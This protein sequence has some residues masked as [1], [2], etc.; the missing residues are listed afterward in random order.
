[1]LVRKKVEFMVHPWLTCRS[2]DVKHWKTTAPRKSFRRIF[3]SI[4]L[5]WN[6]F[7]QSICLEFTSW[8]SPFPCSKEPWVT[9]NPIHLCSLSLICNKL[10][11][12]KHHSVAV[13]KRR[14]RYL[15]R[16]K[17]YMTMILQ[18]LHVF[19]VS[20]FREFILTCNPTR[21]QTVKK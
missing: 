11:A 4:K 21:L 8:F 14:V 12:N 15:N 20:N 18:L 2:A 1:M 3:V 10:G 19:H 6:E 13:Q 5:G 16:P 17:S 9:F 7:T